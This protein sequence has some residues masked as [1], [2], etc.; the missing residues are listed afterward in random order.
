MYSICIANFFFEDLKQFDG[1]ELAKLENYLECKL[2]DLFETV[3][4]DCGKIRHELE[5][6]DF[7]P[8]YVSE[9]LYDL[10]HD[11]VKEKK[12]WYQFSLELDAYMNSYVYEEEKLK[13]EIKETELC[14]TAFPFEGNQLAFTDI[15]KRVLEKTGLVPFVDDYSKS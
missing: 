11:G 3:V 9:L 14:I 8:K 4:V 10:Y 1:R 13:F 12:G 6:K 15:S 7:F 5:R 2:K